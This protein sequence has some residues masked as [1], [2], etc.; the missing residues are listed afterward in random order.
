MAWKAG[1]NRAN[2]GLNRCTVG[3]A[4]VSPPNADT[5]VHML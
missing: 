5:P 1:T 2:Q 3:Q 4:A